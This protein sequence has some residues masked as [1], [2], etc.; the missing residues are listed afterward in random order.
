MVTVRLLKNLPAKAG[1]SCDLSS[2]VLTK[3]E[4]SCEGGYSQ[5]VV[6]IAKKPVQS[7][8]FSLNLLLKGVFQQPHSHHLFIYS[9]RR[10]PSESH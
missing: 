10:Q 9:S 2:I 5:Q 3:E 6:S 1:L 8:D 7:T 4:A